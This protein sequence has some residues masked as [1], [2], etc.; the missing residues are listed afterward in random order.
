MKVFKKAY[1]ISA[2]RKEVYDAFIN[3]D[4]I[5]VW[6]GQE[7]EM[8]DEEGASF[9][10]WGHTIY[11][12]NKIVSIDRIVQDWQENTWEKPSLVTFIFSDAEQGTNI[13]LIHEEIPDQSYEGIKSGWD[14]YYVLPLKDFVENNN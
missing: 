2:P 12:V 1:F 7:A 11:G 9:S 8:S 13:E 6:S 3:P 4:K 5:A 10:L 14:D